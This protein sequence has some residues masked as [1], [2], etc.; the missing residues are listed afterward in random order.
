MKKLV[1]VLFALLLVGSFAFAEVNVGAWGRL[2]FVP[3]ASLSGDV[4]TPDPIAF[5]GPQ[6]GDGMNVGFAVG[7]SNEHAGFALD[8]DYNGGSI[9]FGDQAKAWIQ[10]NEMIKI[11]FGKIQ[12]DVLR[13]KIDDSGFLGAIPALELIPDDPSTTAVNEQELAP[14][15]VKTTG[16]DD[17]FKRFYPQGGMLLNVTP[18]EGIYIGA[19]L[20]VGEKGDAILTQDMFKTIQVG[21]GYVIANVGHLRAQYIGGMD[22]MKKYFQAAFAYT[23]IEGILVDAGIKYQMESK[24]GKSTG[25]VSATYK[26]DALSAVARLAVLFGEDGANDDLGYKASGDVSYVV[27]DPLS[28]GA[29]VA[30]QKEGDPMG[31]TVVPY[32]Q[33]SYAGGFLK[34]GFEYSS[35]TKQY[36][37]AELDYSSWAIPLMMQYSF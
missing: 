19:A 6:W 36:G 18:A 21:A 31:F 17:I 28:V 1:S 26:K 35:F 10:P 30:F 7:G 27:A 12:G 3:A 25:A 16:K 23:A 32:G 14:F 20:D 11:E 5:T 9:G 4:E 33:I 2:M 13:G 8:L 29:E 15:V 24:A 37:A 22:D 34:A